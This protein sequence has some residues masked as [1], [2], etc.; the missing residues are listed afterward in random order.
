MDGPHAARAELGEDPVGAET[1]A[2][3]GPQSAE[4]ESRARAGNR[5]ASLA[6]PTAEVVDAARLRT[7][8]E[9][10]RQLLRDVLGLPEEDRV[11]IATEVLASLDGP[12]DADWDAAWVAELQ[13]RQQAA[14][15]RGEPAPEWA[16]VRARILMRL[17][18][19]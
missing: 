6:G 15:D 10:A 12:P 14:A 11:R 4:L 18:R 17:G 16:E 1:A 7:V 5:K 9:P 13:R 19:E 3:H 8:T 2:D